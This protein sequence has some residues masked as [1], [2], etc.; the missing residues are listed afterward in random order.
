MTN[1]LWLISFVC[2]SFC[3]GVNVCVGLCTKKFASVQRWYGF[4][5]QLLE[6]LGCVSGEMFHGKLGKG[7]VEDRKLPLQ[8][9]L[10]QE[11]THTEAEDLESFL[12]SGIPG[13]AQEHE[14]PVL[15][16]ALYCPMTLSR[17]VP[18]CS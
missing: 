8:T 2:V 4:C 17:P 7:E 11:A 1:M 6:G 10:H 9:S 15:K 18:L 12:L 16:M 13:S 5:L 14:C 3:T